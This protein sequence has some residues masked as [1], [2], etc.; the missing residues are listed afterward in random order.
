M[1]TNFPRDKP[2]AHVISLDWENCC[3]LNFP[4]NLVLRQGLETHKK[5]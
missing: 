4:V 1:K 5:I 3:R 2:L